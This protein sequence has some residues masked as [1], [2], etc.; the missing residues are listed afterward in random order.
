MNR[1]HFLLTAAAFAVAPSCPL[2]DERSAPTR[3]MRFDPK[4]VRI[5]WVGPGG[6]VLLEGPVSGD[7]QSFPF[8]EGDSY[9]YSM[10]GHVATVT[11]KGVA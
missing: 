2:V 9:G 11:V 6:D 4:D 5:T 1:R 7:W 3:L 10:G 8:P